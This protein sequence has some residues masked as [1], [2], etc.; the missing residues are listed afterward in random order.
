MGKQEQMVKW[1]G[2]IHCGLPLKTEENLRRV[3]LVVVDPITRTAAM[4]MMI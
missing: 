3:L 2:A 1:R 4:V